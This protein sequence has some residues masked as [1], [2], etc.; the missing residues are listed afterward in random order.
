MGM[1]LRRHDRR[2]EER[3]KV[4]GKEIIKPAKNRRLGSLPSYATTQS[5]NIVNNGGQTSVN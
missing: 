3:P 4:N 5:Q 1:L 2:A